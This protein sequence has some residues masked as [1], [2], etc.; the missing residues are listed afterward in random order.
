MKTHAKRDGADWILNGSKDVDHQ[1]QP[2]RASP[3]VWA[4]TDDG[5]QGFVGGEAIS[6]LHCPGNP[7]ED[8]PARLVTRALFF[9]NVRVPEANR[10]T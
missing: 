6:P 1:R 7:Q 3:I 5:I 8:E 10:P 4:Q 9:D 2:S